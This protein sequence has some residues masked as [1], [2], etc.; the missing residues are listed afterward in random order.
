MAD[1][2]FTSGVELEQQ[3]ESTFI[4]W[5]YKN[6]KWMTLINYFI[7]YIP[8]AMDFHYDFF[9]SN[10]A[11]LGTILHL[12]FNGK[13]S[14]DEDVLSICYKKMP[15]CIEPVELPRIIYDQDIELPTLKTEG[16]IFIG[17]YDNPEFDGESITILKAE[18]I[19]QSIKLYAKWE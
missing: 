10:E 3:S 7:E 17:W 5:C 13:Y 18:D 11:S 8:I 2:L 15:L 6:D 1:A 4:G 19:K 14:Y 12:L 16:R 9:Y